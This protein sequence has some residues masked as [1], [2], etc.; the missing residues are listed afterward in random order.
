M[1]QQNA[2]HVPQES[3]LKPTHVTI[4]LRVDI[5]QKGCLTASSVQLNISVLMVLLFVIVL[6]IENED[7]YTTMDSATP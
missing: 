7:Q 4:V 2:T 5:Q 6:V 3:G 1:G